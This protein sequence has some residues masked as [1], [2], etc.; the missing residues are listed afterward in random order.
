MMQ[1]V[2]DKMWDRAKSRWTGL[3]F[4]SKIFY[5]QAHLQDLA[6]EH[7]TKMDGSE[8][9]KLA[10]LQVESEGTIFERGNA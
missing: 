1:S 3:G 2:R 8:A 9:Y 7:G 10:R 5:L 4:H 6:R